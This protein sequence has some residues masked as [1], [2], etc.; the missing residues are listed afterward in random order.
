MLGSS[1]YSLYCAGYDLTRRFRG[2]TIGELDE[3]FYT[4]DHPRLLQIHSSAK[5]VSLCWDTTGTSHILHPRINDSRCSGKCFPQVKYQDG[6]QPPMQS[7]TT[8][9]MV[10]YSGDSR[11]HDDPPSLL[12]WSFEMI[13]GLDCHSAAQAE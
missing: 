8:K 12:G 1:N 11:N 4:I 3:V 6:H 5:R 2:H 10:I 13:V 9:R 7:R